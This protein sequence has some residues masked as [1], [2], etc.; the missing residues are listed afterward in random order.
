MILERHTNLK[1]KYGNC[2][3]YCTGY[4]VENAV[5]IEEYIRNQ[6]KE[7]FEYDPISLNE[8]SNLF[9]VS[10]QERTKKGS[11]EPAKTAIRKVNSLRFL[12]CL[13]YWTVLKVFVNLCDFLVYYQFEI[14][15]INNYRC[16]LKCRKG[17]PLWHC[18]I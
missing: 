1:Y 8:Y 6:L 12:L 4:Y 10:R 11:L 9:M 18:D 16:S 7:N 5:E 13:L 17:G 14:E 2:H 15:Y 3:F